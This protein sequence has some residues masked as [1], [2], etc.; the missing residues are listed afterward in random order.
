VYLLLLDE[1]DEGTA[2]RNAKNGSDQN[3]DE[4]KDFQKKRSLFGNE[5]A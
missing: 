4:K 5:A 2:G 1:E 3:V